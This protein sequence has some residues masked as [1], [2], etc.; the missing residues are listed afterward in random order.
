M[1][2]LA[3]RDAGPRTHLGPVR[4]SVFAPV[5]GSR[6]LRARP[7]GATSAAQMVQ[8]LAVRRRPHARFGPVVQAAPARRTADAEAFDRKHL[9]GDAAAEHEDDAPQAPP[10]V[11]DRVAA[12]GVWRMVEPLPLRVGLDAA[13]RR[14]GS[15]ICL[16]APL[17]A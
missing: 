13:S 10:M 2:R 16:W 11:F 17:R 6:R 8:H 9:P 7:Y 5:R 15:E 1:A 4:S 14:H 12:L 3:R